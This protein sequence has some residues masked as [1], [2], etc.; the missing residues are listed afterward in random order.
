MT[1]GILIVLYL[2]KIVHICELWH[3]WYDIL[4]ISI[5]DRIILP[6]AVLDS[7]LLLR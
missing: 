4:E 1:L 3:Q 6:A 7:V 5:R 2:S